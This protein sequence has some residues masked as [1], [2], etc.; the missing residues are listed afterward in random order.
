MQLDPNIRITHLIFQ[1]LIKVTSMRQSILGAE[2]VED[3]D[4]FQPQKPLQI[5]R[6]KRKINILEMKLKIS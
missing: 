4:S 3:N 1:L 6:K 2:G 5:S